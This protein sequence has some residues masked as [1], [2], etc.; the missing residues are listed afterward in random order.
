MSLHGTRPAR[1]S[2]HSN[3]FS[4]AALR[5]TSPYGDAQQLVNAAST[6]QLPD[7][8]RFTGDGTS[9]SIRDILWSD[10]SVSVTHTRARSGLL[11]RQCA[12]CLD[13]TRGNFHTG[14]S[15]GSCL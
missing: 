3:V 7:D 15:P 10:D 12:V 13:A 2:A 9:V 4:R 14:N 6:K 1:V 8:G 11:R 5:R